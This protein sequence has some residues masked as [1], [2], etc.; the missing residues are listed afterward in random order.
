[1]RIP[2]FNAEASLYGSSNKYQ[3]RGA[4]TDGAA[5]TVVPAAILNRGAMCFSYAG[6][7]ICVQQSIV[8]ADPVTINAVGPGD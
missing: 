5:A 6:D 1:M 2:S 3:S 8:L 4:G 7:V